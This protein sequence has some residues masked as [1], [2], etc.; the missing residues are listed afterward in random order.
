ME[1]KVLSK[2]DEA[3]LHLM[4]TTSITIEN[5]YRRST[6]GS[7]KKIVFKTPWVFRALPVLASFDITSISKLNIY[8]RSN[9]ETFVNLGTGTIAQAIWNEMP[10][11][12]KVVK[13]MIIT[14]SSRPELTIAQIL[15]IVDRD[16]E[17]PT[18]LPDKIS[19]LDF[20][21]RYPDFFVELENETFTTNVKTV[22][23]F[24]YDATRLSKV[25]NLIVM[26]Y[27]QRFV[28][29][30]GLKSVYVTLKGIQSYL[31]HF[32]Y[33]VS[34][35]ALQNFVDQ[36]F[37]ITPRFD[38]ESAKMIVVDPEPIEPMVDDSETTTST[39]T[40]LEF[41]GPV[42]EDVESVDA[43]EETVQA[44]MEPS[45]ARDD[46]VS[47]LSDQ[48]SDA[49]PEC[50]VKLRQIFENCPIGICE[51]RKQLQAQGIQISKKV[52]RLTIETHFPEFKI[53]ESGTILTKELQYA[54]MV[55][56]ILKN[57]CPINLGD[58]RKAL[59]SQGT[60]LNNVVL[61]SVIDGHLPKYSITDGWVDLAKV[62]TPRA[63]ANDLP[64][65]R[66]MR[67]VQAMLK[68]KCPIH[69][70][71]V[72]G[73]MEKQ[74]V[75]I[76][77][78][79]LRKEL[80]AHL[81]EFTII[82][83]F[84]VRTQI[85]S[86]VMT[87]VKE[88]E[89]GNENLKKLESIL[90]KSCPI[91]LSKIREQLRATGISMSNLNLRSTIEKNLPDFKTTDN[92]IVMSVK[93]DKIN[94]V[95]SI[96][97]ESCP[98]NMGQVRAELKVQGIQ[99]NN[100]NLRKIL[101]DYL[102]EFQIGNGGMIFR[103]DDAC[104]KA[105]ESIAKRGC[106]LGVH[107]ILTELSAKGIR[108]SEAN[109]RYVAKGFLLDL[110]IKADDEAVDYFEKDILA[111]DESQNSSDVEET[112]SEADY[113]DDESSGDEFTNHLLSSIPKVHLQLIQTI[114]D[115]KCPISITEIRMELISHSISLSRSFL[116]DLIV[117]EISDCFIVEGFVYLPT[118]ISA[119]GSFMANV[120]LEALRSIMQNEWSHSI[121]NLVHILSTK[122]IEI[123][124][125]KLERMISEFSYKYKC[126]DGFVSQVIKGPKHVMD[127][128][129]LEEIVECLKSLDVDDNNSLKVANEKRLFKKRFLEDILGNNDVYCLL[130]S[131]IVT[132]E[133][134]G[135]VN[136]PEAQATQIRDLDEP[137]FEPIAQLPPI[138][139]ELK[140]PSPE[141]GIQL[142]QLRPPLE[143]NPE[144][145]AQ[146]SHIDEPH[147][148]PLTQPAF[149]EET[150]MAN[151][152]EDPLF[153]SSALELEVPAN[154][155]IETAEEVIPNLLPP[156][157]R[158]ADLDQLRRKL[159]QW[160]IFLDEALDMTEDGEGPSNSDDLTPG[161]ANL[162]DLPTSTPI[163]PIGNGPHLV[164]KLTSSIAK[165]ETKEKKKDDCI[166]S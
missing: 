154:E 45:D 112:Q 79:K 149:I 59:D 125:N 156:S 144:L 29:Q 74:G 165:L 146:S 30:N 81:P 55:E 36:F 22:C 56:R 100:I 119:E 90:K 87:Q 95:Q 104:R 96:L 1:V 13:F 76:C 166:L 35:E 32:S 129:S 113:S 99:M 23:S 108:M 126:Q 2:V 14:L 34:L 127:P 61:R 160:D 130:K 41:L 143:T 132:E 15:A 163:N 50:V 73:R 139:K 69:V 57:D 54:K 10:S 48:P 102:P 67:M 38:E 66:E 142:A 17:M 25:D 123:T 75:D 86:Q 94:A 88:T 122:S 157:S 92:G 117:M 52:L 148:K 64:L 159:P 27:I 116:R 106:A 21:R 98:I 93:A 141:P 162:P 68:V 152:A 49:E 85:Q 153:L 16:H 4:S 65:P 137:K 62:P 115:E 110:N 3:I 128:E 140:E 83:T 53:G 103:F 47:N 111:S 107:D 51:V 18:R 150:K 63:S 133:G 71:E 82:K 24:Q 135:F 138:I 89:K 7:E 145:N 121:D 46:S 164:A 19:V 105:L 124:Q 158:S 6:N 91:N 31:R 97:N 161:R 114:L 136:P 134:I 58:I 40:V 155:D 80:R 109:L 5:S 33:E 84:I 70:A 42:F 37:N 12:I 120:V 26:E 39:T 101:A 72:I 44:A 78:T 43:V 77:K 151:V 9:A 147:P 118:S 11:E 20:L 28:N 60:I 131:L 8:L